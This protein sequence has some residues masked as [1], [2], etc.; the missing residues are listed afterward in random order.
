[1]TVRTQ[2]PGIAGSIVERISIA[3]IDMEAEGFAVP[4]RNLTA[5]IADFRHPHVQESAP[6]TVG[7]LSDSSTS[8]IHEHV[9]MREFLVPTDVL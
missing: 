6:K 1:M 2:Q 5:F 4:L 8:V 9:L 7:G 3:M